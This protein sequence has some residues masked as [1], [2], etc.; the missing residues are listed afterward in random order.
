MFEFYNERER[1][2]I[3][4]RLE[5]EKIKRKRNSSFHNIFN[6]KTVKINSLKGDIMKINNKELEGKL[7]LSINKKK[8]IQINKRNNNKFSLYKSKLKK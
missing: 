6:C 5:S 7:L 8:K 3:N 2:L 4:K 1:E